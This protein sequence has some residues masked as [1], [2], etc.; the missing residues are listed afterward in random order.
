[1]AVGDDQSLPEA[2]A[3][4]HAILAYTRLALHMGVAASSAG[5]DIGSS[6]N[7]ADGPGMPMS[8]IEVVSAIMDAYADWSCA[9]NLAH[10]CTSP[11]QEL[12]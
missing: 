9:R 8:Q 11:C 1:M 7:Q 3:G 12:M 5:L 4:I 10:K 6:H 2:R